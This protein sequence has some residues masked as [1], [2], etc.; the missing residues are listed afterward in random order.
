MKTQLKHKKRDY[1]SF[2][3][4]IKILER[5]VDFMPKHR[6]KEAIY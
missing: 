4:T 2:V 6:Q 1:N 3:E 5:K